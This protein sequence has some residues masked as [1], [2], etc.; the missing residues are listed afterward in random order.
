MMLVL[1][2]LLMMVMVGFI[3][4][5][6]NSIQHTQVAIANLDDGPLSKTFISSLETMNNQLGY[7]T[8]SNATGFDDIKMQIQNGK[9][10]GGIIISE[11]FTACLMMEEWGNITIITDQT[12]PQMS[13]ML[14]NILSAVIAQLGTQYAIF[15]LN[16]TY[17]VPYQIQE[18]VP[19]N[20]HLGGIIP[21]NPSYFE[22][23]AP[24]IMAMVVMM[25]LMTGLP[26][27][28]SYEKDTGTLDGMLVAPVNRMSII[29]G[30]TLAQVTRGLIQGLIVLLL[31]IFLFGVT[32]YG[33]IGLVFLILFLGVF[34][35]VGLGILITSFTGK[36]ETAAMIMM[37]IM[38]PM[39]FL[40]G[41]FFPISQMPLA[42]QYIAQALPLT[43]AATALRKVIILGADIP[44]IT[45]ELIFLIVFG[46]VFLIIAIPMFKRAMSR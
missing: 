5:S 19:Y 18:V 2:P 7:F 45:N 38:F 27:A 31:A 30:K 4:P 43:Y 8:L 26:H 29:V 11:N 20:I 33:N 16:T 23:M 32:I 24:G 44:A 37:T 40:S 21:G 1:M 46:L 28:I 6:T 39:M 13:L 35:F 42:M 22:F 34:S 9:I 14:Q 10:S 25:A 17:G 41:V 3:F 15:H 12:N 36:E